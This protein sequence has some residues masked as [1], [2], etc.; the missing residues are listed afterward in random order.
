MLFAG[1]FTAA[2]DK[3][4]NVLALATDPSNDMLITGDSS[5]HITVLD[6]SSY[7]ISRA[8]SIIAQVS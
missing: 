6:I 5:G 3:D 7:C 8:E 1:R 2:T 4:S